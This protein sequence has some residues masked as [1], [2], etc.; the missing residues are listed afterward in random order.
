MASHYMVLYNYSS[1]LTGVARYCNNW[2]WWE[3]Y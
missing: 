2:S 1:L 3:I